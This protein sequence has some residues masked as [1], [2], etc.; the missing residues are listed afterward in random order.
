[1]REVKHTKN[2]EELKRLQHGMKLTCAA[3]EGFSLLLSSPNLTN[4]AGASA[5]PILPFASL[6][7]LGFSSHLHNRLYPHL[8]A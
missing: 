7:F 3:V 1:M 5:N 8:N 2:R 4:R 6:K